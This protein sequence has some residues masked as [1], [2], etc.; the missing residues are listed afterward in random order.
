MSLGPRITGLVPIRNGYKYLP[1]FRANLD[2]ILGLNDELLVIDDRSE[3]GTLDF[4]KSWANDDARIKV[5]Q[6]SGSGLVDALN[7]GLVSASNSW[8]ARFDVDDRYASNRFLIQRDRLHE[9]LEAI[10]SDYQFFSNTELDLGRV[11]TAVLPRATALSLISGQRTAHPSVI[12]NKQL[13]IEVGGYISSDFPAE[14]L[15]LWLRLL[16][17][18]SIESVENLLLFYQISSTS[19]TGRNR[20]LA[21]EKRSG[22]INSNNN[23]KLIFEESIT[24]LNRTADF[25]LNCEDGSHRFVL[26]IRDIFFAG[27]SYGFNIKYILKVFVAIMR[28][29][30]LD[31]LR[32]LLDIRKAYK[33]RKRFR[34]NP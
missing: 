7:Y 34:S 5:L 25:Y 26:H 8:I 20:K 29:G 4:L 22:L 3:D 31:F 12:F 33:L 32:A 13:A 2:Q 1:D 11:F 24:E 21:I 19:V 16:K 14:D 17:V 15:S 18:G 30:I 28:F 10:F 27:K 9:S 23:L 6:N